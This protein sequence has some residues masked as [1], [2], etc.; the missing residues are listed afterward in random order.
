M[1]SV[2]RKWVLL[3]NVG[4]V[5]S[6]E[7]IMEFLIKDIRCCHVF[8]LS[9]SPLPAELQ[10]SQH[11]NAVG[12]TDRSPSWCRGTALSL[13]VASLEYTSCGAFVLRYGANAPSS[14]SVPRASA[15]SR[16]F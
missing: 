8:F 6:M 14:F 16:H 4:N 5:L 15:F 10:K 11:D 9:S 13:V 2:V 1:G 12:D 7:D 3:E